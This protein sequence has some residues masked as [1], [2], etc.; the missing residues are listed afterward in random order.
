M[1]KRKTKE[2][3]IEQARKIHGNK[4]DYS[5]VEYIDSLIPVI[6]ICPIHKEFNQKPCYHLQSNGCP[7][8]NNCGYSKAQIQWL[9]FIQLK[10]KIKTDNVPDWFLM[11]S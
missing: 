7:K 3:F 11:F 4:Y 2:E 8:C 9:N 6:I 1:G 5:K 10:D